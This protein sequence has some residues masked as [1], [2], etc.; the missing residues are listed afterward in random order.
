MLLTSLL[1]HSRALPRCSATRIQSRMAITSCESIPGSDG[2]SRSRYGA[3]TCP[4]LQDPQRQSRS[5]AVSR[6]ENVRL[7]RCFPWDSS[8]DLRVY[9]AELRRSPRLGRRYFASLQPQANHSRPL[10][11]GACKHGLRPAHLRA[12]WKAI[13]PVM[14]LKT[15]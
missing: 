11:P 9:S 1:S 10:A 3:S 4:C 12:S 15:E 5:A 6:N 7:C 13:P 8:K 2:K 14:Q